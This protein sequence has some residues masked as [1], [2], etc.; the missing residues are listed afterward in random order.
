MIFKPFVSWK[1]IGKYL[2]FRQMYIS[3]DFYLVFLVNWT[4][5]HNYVNHITWILTFTTLC[6]PTIY[7]FNWKMRFKEITWIYSSNFILSFFSFCKFHFEWIFQFHLALCKIHR[8]LAFQLN[9]IFCLEK[10]G[11]FIG[12]FYL[13][14]RLYEKKNLFY[15]LFNL[16]GCF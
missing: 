10:K 13:F 12:L 5:R 6:I 1:V 7:M 16:I 3:F 8:L 9:N 14:S 11:I 15:I 4:H 2:L